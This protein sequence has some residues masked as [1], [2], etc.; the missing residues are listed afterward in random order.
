MKICILGTGRQG[1]AAAYDILL[2]AKPSTLLLLD[3]NSKSIDDCIKKISKVSSKKIKIEHHVIDLNDVS[4]L[5]K[6]LFLLKYNLIKFKSSVLI[7]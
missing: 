2:Y 5:S 7:K 6:F 1:C 4:L 3:N